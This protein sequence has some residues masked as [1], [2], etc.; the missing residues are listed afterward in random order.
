MKKVIKFKEGSLKVEEFKDFVAFRNWVEKNCSREFY[1]YLFPKD[2][3][4]FRYIEDEKLSAYVS[5]FVIDPY[6]FDKNRFLEETDED[7]SVE[8][9]LSRY[10]EHEVLIEAKCHID[11]HD[12]TILEVNT[13]KTYL[14]MLE[15]ALSYCSDV[16][17]YLVGNKLF[18]FAV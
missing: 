8:E 14:P 9:V 4:E 5:N 15:A 2:M 11:K 16:F 12:R 7:E 3:D 6:V 18:V 10:P 13:E 17:Y 1:K